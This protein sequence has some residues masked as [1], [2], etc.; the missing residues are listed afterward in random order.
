[1]KLLLKKIQR[2]QRFKPATD[3]PLT[4]TP[5][6]MS[7][8]GRM[9]TRRW[10]KQSLQELDFVIEELDAELG[11]NEHVETC[12]MCQAEL[13]LSVER[14]LGS[15]GPWWIDL[16]NGDYLPEQYPDCPKVE[17]YVIGSYW[18]GSSDDTMRFIKDRMA[19]ANKIIE[20]Q[21]KAACRLVKILENWPVTRGIPENSWVQGMIDEVAGIPTVFADNSIEK[22][23]EEESTTSF[24]GVL[25]WKRS[26]EYSKSAAENATSVRMRSRRS[27]DALQKMLKKSGKMEDEPE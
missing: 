4:A 18:T 3:I 24:F 22:I 15:R 17:D 13:H 26:R 1:M 14:Y 12:G 5:E 21:F 20:K 7:L 19:W 8:W 16:R 9:Q 25:S 10:I 2:P 6:F 23:W 11:F 27:L